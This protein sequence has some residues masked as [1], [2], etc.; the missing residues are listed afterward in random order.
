MSN[1]SANKRTF[2]SA[3]RHVWGLG[4]FRAYYRGLTVRL[5]RVVTKSLCKVYLIID[6]LGRRLPVRPSPGS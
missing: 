4:G 6:W 3:I 2:A 5:V 1:T